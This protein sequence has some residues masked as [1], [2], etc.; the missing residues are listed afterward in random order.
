[1][2]RSEYFEKIRQYESKWGK[3]GESKSIMHSAETKE[4]EENISVTEEYKRFRKKVAEGKNREK[5]IHSTIISPEELNARYHQE[6]FD[7]GTLIHS[8]INKYYR[9]VDLGNGK[10]RYFYSK[11][12]YEA[13]QDNKKN[14][15]TGGE[16]AGDRE[17]EYV[18][19]SKEMNKYSYDT[20]NGS[21]SFSN[22][23]TYKEHYER[24]KTEGNLKEYPSNKDISKDENYTKPTIETN[25]E[26]MKS[27]QGAEQAGADR[28]AKEK[29]NAKNVNK[30]PYVEKKS[31]GEEMADVA[32]KTLKDSENAA[33]S[34]RNDQGRDAAIKAG[35]EST[36]KSNYATE[37]KNNYRQ[38]AKE[39]TDVSTKFN[40][41]YGADKVKTQEEADE[42]TKNMIKDI[43]KAV[44]EADPKEFRNSD[45]VK[46]KSDD[47]NTNLSFV[48]DEYEKE[49]EDLNK[50]YNKVQNSNISTSEK[51]DKLSEIQEEIRKVTKEYQYTV[52]PYGIDVM[53]YILNK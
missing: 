30:V 44:N 23:D 25:K 6:L 52:F 13:Y 24:D 45:K 36:K 15:K 1:M 17:N 14:D 32:K 33:R 7:N 43:K 4:E 22:Y 2:T 8:D 29:E 37:V 41:A 19:P 12:E 18:S 49:L 47:T 10:Y 46:I 50:E 3:I 34:K 31:E 5:L 48:V 38:S 9:K 53:N 27:K 28:A 42:V 35:Q 20:K 16:A 40:Q 11:E 39:Y 21:A 51:V 26:Y